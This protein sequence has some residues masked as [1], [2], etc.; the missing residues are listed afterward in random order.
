MPIKAP[1]IRI[2]SPA[3][4][5]PFGR[6]FYQLEEEILYLPVEYQAER[7]KFFSF[8]ESD[9]VSMQFNRDGRLIFIELTLPRRHWIIRHEVC[10]PRV[11]GEGDIRWLDFR[12]RMSNPIIS[13]DRF[14]QNV[15]IEFSSVI[16]ASAFYLAKNLIAQISA[17]DFLVG[18][19]ATDFVEDLAGREFATWRKRRFAP[20]I[21]S[22]LRWP[23][24][25]SNVILM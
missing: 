2:A 5:V 12:E 19:W 20:G 14:Q 13:C 10:F 23:Y 16:P 8:I 3:G 18:I 24:S 21:G 7:S 17:D 4:S 22:L 1:K 15:H 11:A 6:G 9:T 25:P